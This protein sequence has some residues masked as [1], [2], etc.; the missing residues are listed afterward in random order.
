MEE[1]DHLFL[2]KI[3]QVYNDTRDNI[4]QFVNNNKGVSSTTTIDHNASSIVFELKT[5][6][7]E[8]ELKHKKEM[9]DNIVLTMKMISMHN[10]QIKTSSS[11]SEKAPIIGAMYE[12]QV[13]DYLKSM[14]PTCKFTSQAHIA[15]T[16]DILIHFPCLAGRNIQEKKEVL[17][18]IEVKYRSNVNAMVEQEEFD[19]FERDMHNKKHGALGGVFFTN[20]MLPDYG[21]P[22][23]R[24]LFGKVTEAFIGGG[25]LSDLIV[26]ILE[27]Y[28]HIS[29][30]ILCNQ[31]EIEKPSDQIVS[32]FLEELLKSYNTNNDFIHKI[33]SKCSNHQKSQNKHTETL[34]KSFQEAKA[35]QPHLFPNNTMEVLTNH[36]IRKRQKTASASSSINSSSSSS[37]TQSSTQSLTRSQMKI[38]QQSLDT[39]LKYDKW[40][41][42]V[43]ETGIPMCDCNIPCVTNTS[44]LGKMYH[45]CHKCKFFCFQTDF[46]LQKNQILKT[47]SH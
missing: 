13:M 8:L 9:E 40:T 4:L 21:T 16:C 35:V 45:I 23:Q 22:G 41:P 46:H 6:I 39:M 28:A 2:Q 15:H 7:Q 34:L 19:K 32:K 29:S 26:V 3:T 31:Q 18:L 14:L 47:S 12:K 10:E 44:R 17:I 43:L 1:I 11:I 20:A 37:L 42:N 30:M 24:I 36:H 5:K 27:M 38:N 33:K 25:L